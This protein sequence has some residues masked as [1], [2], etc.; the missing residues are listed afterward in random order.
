[1]NSIKNKFLV[2]IKIVMKKKKFV[3]GKIERIR[4]RKK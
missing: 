2:E 1:M 4:E 3:F